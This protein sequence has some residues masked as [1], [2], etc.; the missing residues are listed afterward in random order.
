MSLIVNAPIFFE[1][2]FPAMNEDIILLYL[3]HAYSYNSAD[4]YR[5]ICIILDLL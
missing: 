4:I 3:Y 5:C 2:I 1:A